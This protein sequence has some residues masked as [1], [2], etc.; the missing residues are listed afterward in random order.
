MMNN[1]LPLSSTKRTIIANA[2]IVLIA[3]GGVGFFYYQIS[4]TIQKGEE[5]RKDLA[6][7]Q[8]R[9]KQLRS[10]RHLVEDT[11]SQRQRLRTY[12]IP[13]E[14]VPEYINTVEK[15][16]KEA[17]VPLAITSVGVESYGSD[18][19]DGTQNT[20]QDN[21]QSGNAGDASG[22]E[23]APLEKVVLQLSVKEASWARTYHFLRLLEELPRLQRVVDMSVSRNQEEETPGWNSRFV[24]H[25]IKL[26]S[27]TNESDS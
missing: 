20:T 8:Q 13:Q 25:A 15:L 3:I 6:F 7:E 5:L 10:I 1:M 21:T 27:H 9:Q 19:T 23:S 11:A 12:F 24:V 2:I 22:S 18:S 26:T 4:Q 14:G 17:E 16:A